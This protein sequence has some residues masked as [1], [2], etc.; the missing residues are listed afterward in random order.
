MKRV[1][2]NGQIMALS[3]LLSACAS[4]QPQAEV[5]D[6]RHYPVT[7][8]FG[9][10]SNTLL[11]G[12]C[13]KH[14]ED[15]RDCRV[16]MLDIA[17]NR[18]VAFT[19]PPGRYLHMPSLAADG[20]SILAVATAIDADEA[21]NRAATIVRF[22]PQAPDRAQVVMSSANELLMPS[23][24]ESGFAAWTKLCETPTQRYCSIDP[25]VRWPGEAKPHGLGRSYGFRMIGPIFTANK[26]IY[27]DA[28]FP[29][30]LDLDHYDILSRED[31]NRFWRLEPATSLGYE[32]V[33]QRGLTGVTGARDAKARL[34]LHGEDSEG[35]GYFTQTRTGFQREANVLDNIPGGS[36][37]SYAVDPSG[38][39]FVIVLVFNR[40]TDKITTKVMVSHQRTSWRDLTLPAP[41]SL[42]QLQI[43]L[44]K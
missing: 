11:L 15:S 5:A 43:E 24:T 14:A 31:T 39:D 10:D 20:K 1:R 26:K 7:V 36:I 19:A 27:A 25:L 9:P 21:G 34:Y 40:R 30:N 29:E 28:E 22:D 6:G 44:G 42:V 41:S 12:T 35:L 8:S 4:A 33:A 3:L 23:E 37:Q 18:S 13:P 16:E 32:K 38:S 2:P 17:K